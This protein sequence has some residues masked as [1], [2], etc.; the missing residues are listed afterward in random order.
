[1]WYQTKPLILILASLIGL[2]SAPASFAEQAESKPISSEEYLIEQSQPS[3]VSQLFQNQQPRTLAQ[4][5]S[6]AQ[7]IL[8]NLQQH[9]PRVALVLGGG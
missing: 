3:Q 8:F 4:S 7:P 6:C 9:R 2:L 1:M 5:Q